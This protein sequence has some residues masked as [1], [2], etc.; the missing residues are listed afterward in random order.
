MLFFSLDLNLLK[1]KKF[2]KIHRKSIENYARVVLNTIYNSGE[3]TADNLFSNF[4][5]EILIKYLGLSDHFSAFQ[6][7][8]L[9]L[10]N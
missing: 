7:S 3:P 9:Y 1:I 2:K 10:N 5:H 6:T 8:E 4:L